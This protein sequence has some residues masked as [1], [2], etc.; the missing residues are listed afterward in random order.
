MFHCPDVL[1][2][3]ASLWSLAFQFDQITP[4]NHPDQ[5]LRIAL[6]ERLIKDIA[7]KIRERHVPLVYVFRAQDPGLR[8]GFLRVIGEHADPVHFL[9]ALEWIA[10]ESGPQDWNLKWQLLR[11]Y[12]HM[13]LRFPTD[14]TI[15]DSASVSLQ[16][17]SIGADAALTGGIA[18]MKKKLGIA[19]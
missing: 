6:K 10:Q 1:R 16:F 3:H 11:A 18:D 7:H 9:S 2:P 14:A 5:V 17:L 8:V 4:E 13:F 19:S 15:V 12:R